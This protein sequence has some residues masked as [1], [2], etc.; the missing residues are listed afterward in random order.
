MGEEQVL[1]ES[2]IVMTPTRHQRLSCTG[3]KARNVFTCNSR[4]LLKILAIQRDGVSIGSWLIPP[5]I[6]NWLGWQLEV[7]RLDALTP[8]LLAEQVH[9]SIPKQHLAIKGF[10]DLPDS[11]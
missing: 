7:Q 8:F 4:V 3:M 10:S 9:Y 5:S 6:K 11:L 2:Q 1:I